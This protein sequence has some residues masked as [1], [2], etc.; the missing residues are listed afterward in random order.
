MLTLQ[1]RPGLTL[2]FHPNNNHR[3]LHRHRRNYSLSPRASQLALKEWAPTVGAIQ[4][5]DQTFLLRKGGIKEP[6][7]KPPPGQSTFLL[8]PTHFHTDGELIKDSYRTKYK[9]EL[10]YDPRT[11][12]ELE[13]TCL[14]QATGAWTTTDKDV[15]KK[16]STSSSIWTDDFLEARLRWRAQQPLTLLEIRAYRLVL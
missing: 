9:T 2:Q 11:L 14:A 6:T 13:F 15:L 1:P 10:D 4:S 8:F 7:F 5:G 12:Q 16:L 3:S